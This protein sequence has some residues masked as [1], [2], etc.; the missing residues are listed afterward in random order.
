[1]CPACLAS[2]AMLTAGVL[3]SGGLAALV[4]KVVSV[5]KRGELNK[6]N[7]DKET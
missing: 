3:S 4:A 6:I 5:K 7:S 1:M 2:A